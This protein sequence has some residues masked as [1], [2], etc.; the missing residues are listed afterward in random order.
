MSDTENAM[1]TH[2]P[3]T[4]WTEIE[5]AKGEGETARKA[6]GAFCEVYWSPVHGYILR[7]RSRTN[8]Y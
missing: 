7:N 6:L 4:A 5:A 1:N 2:F 8:R 3:A